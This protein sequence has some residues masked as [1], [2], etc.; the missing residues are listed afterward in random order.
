MNKVRYILLLCLLSCSVSL[1]ARRFE[2]VSRDS[3]WQGSRNVAGIRQDSVSI[4]YAEAYGRYEEG[5]FRDSWQ[6]PRTWK[7]GV[8]TESVRHFDRISFTGSFSFDQTEG[9]DMCGSMFIRPGYFPI[10]VLEF[11]PGRKTLQTYMFEGGFAYDLS[12]KWTIGAKMDFESSNL[13]K[14]KDLRHANWRLD[15]TVAPG[16]MYRSG[17]WA[18]GLSPLFRKVAETIDATQVGTSESSYYAFLDKGLMYGVRQVWTGSGVHLQEAGVNG[19]PVREYSYGGSFQVQHHDL[20]ADLEVVRTSGSVGEKEYIW[21]DFPGV[22]VSTNLRY[23]WSGR[24]GVNDVR[25]HFDWSRQDMD[26]R[27][28]EKVSEN[29]ITSVL[30]HGANRIYSRGSWTLNP[31]YGFVHKV[32]DLKA[33]AEFGMCEEMS[34]QVYPYIHTQTLSAS[35]AYLDLVF[36]YL[37]FDFGAEGRFS[38]GWVS[39]SERLSSD[40]SGIQS[41]PYRLQDWYERQMEYKTAPRLDVCAMVRYTFPKGIY[42]EADVRY[43]NAY[44]LKYIDGRSRFTA[45]FKTGL[46]F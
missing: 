13:A 31:E 42:L 20:Y 22:D 33:G 41:E 34:S 2:D 28:L 15:M 5:G 35:S 3:F 21:F 37:S 14:R 45:T 25:L 44:G 6:A 32:F 39:F 8:V 10:D 11:T 1:S 17:G 30:D 19:L 24:S 23:R 46:S 43:V 38:K 26:E 7:A 16:I 9:Y 29:G 18:L 27:V 40:G 12:G 4:S 36:H